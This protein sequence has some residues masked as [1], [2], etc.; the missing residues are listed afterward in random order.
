MISAT[1]QFTGVSP[2]SFSGVVQSPKRDKEAHEDYERRTWMERAHVN[3][4]GYCIIPP[5]FFKNCLSVTAKYL[6]MQIPGKGKTTYT[7]HFEAGVLVVEPVVLDVKRD[8]LQGEWVHVPSDGKRGGTTRVWK[9]FPIIQN[10]GGIVEFL[11]LDNTITSQAF[12][13]HIQ[14]AGKFIGLGRFRPRNNGY[15]GRFQVDDIDW[16]TME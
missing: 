4:D 9:C 3:Q 13:Y 2:I 8:D 6:A 12:S 15:Y 11:V 7:K 10:W 1:V 14:Q 16:R 5:Q